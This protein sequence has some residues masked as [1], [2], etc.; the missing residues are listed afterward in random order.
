MDILRG[1]NKDAVL[2]LDLGISEDGYEFAFDI[3][4]AMTF[5]EFEMDE[6]NTKLAERENILKKLTPECDKTDYVLAAARGATCGLMDMFL[7]G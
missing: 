5:A 4:T 6:I 1:Q 7:V 3:Q 2:L